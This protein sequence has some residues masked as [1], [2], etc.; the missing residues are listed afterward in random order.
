MASD[1]IAHVSE[2][3]DAAARADG[4]RPLSDHLYLDLVNGGLDGFTGFLASEPGHDHPV[5]Y[6]QISRGNDAYAFELVIHP[7][8]RYEMATIGPE[9]IESALDV[10]DRNGNPFDATVQDLKSR[11][12]DFRVCNNT[13]VTRKIDKSKVIPEATD[14][15]E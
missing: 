6:A 13:L 2:L 14:V 1:D 7:H 11:G 12:V 8:H 15:L 9:L 5:A 4:R 10:K 3:L